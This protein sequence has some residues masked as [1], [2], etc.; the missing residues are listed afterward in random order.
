MISS[1]QRT[2][3]HGWQ[4]DV[5]RGTHHSANGTGRAVPAQQAAIRNP[6]GE[7]GRWRLMKPG[8]LLD[9]LRALFSAR[10]AARAAAREADN[11][12]DIQ[13]KQIIMAQLAQT[14]QNSRRGG[15]PVQ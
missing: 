10:K 7:I 2:P 3:A 9:G 13:R 12:R 5:F 4:L 11:R 14:L 15:P 1:Q 6:R 8:R